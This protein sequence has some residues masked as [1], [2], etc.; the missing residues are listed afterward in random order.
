VADLA[1]L[2]TFS[3]DE[4]R[5]ELEARR[6]RARG[7]L[8]T[9]PAEALREYDDHALSEVLAAKQ[10]VIYGVDD[11]VDLFEVTDRSTSRTPTASWRSSARRT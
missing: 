8:A 9:A 5:A 4:L 2:R 1:K 7:A 11:R 3:T 6:A 10:K